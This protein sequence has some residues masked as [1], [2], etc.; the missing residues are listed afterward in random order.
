MLGDEH[1]LEEL[2]YT[3][4][5]SQQQIFDMH[6]SHLHSVLL[7]FVLLIHWQTRQGDLPFTANSFWHHFLCICFLC[8]GKNSY[9]D[10]GFQGHKA[11][12]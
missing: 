4:C 7:P 9:C 1:L 2:E 10:P 5:Q 11:K 3:H 6:S 8:V 12:Q